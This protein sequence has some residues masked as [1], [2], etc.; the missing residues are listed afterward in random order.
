MSYLNKEELLAKLGLETKPS[1][2]QA[3]L[4]ALGPFG[5]GLLVGAGVALLLAPKSGRELRGS[6]RSK[7]GREAGDGASK[8]SESH[9]TI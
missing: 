2:G 4:S 6:I 3:I 9:G 7:I 1:V 5:I 8:G